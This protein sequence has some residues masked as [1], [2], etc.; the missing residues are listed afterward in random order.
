MAVFRRQM[1]KLLE[2]LENS[3][4]ITNPNERTKAF[5]MKILYKSLLWLD[6]ISK[7]FK[8]T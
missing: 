2:D 6:K 7:W 5:F 1:D 8:P 4:I 3:I